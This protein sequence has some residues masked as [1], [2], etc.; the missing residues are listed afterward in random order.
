MKRILCV[1]LLLSLDAVGLAGCYVVSP[2]PPYPPY[3]YPAYI[4]GYQPP[5]TY[6]PP[7][8]GAPRAPGQA[9]ATAAPAPSGTSATQAP[10]VQGAPQGSA[11]NCQTVTV[12]GHF[13]TRV[14]QSGARETIWIPTHDQQMCQ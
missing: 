12:E 14:A 7:S 11:R 13:E 9:G 6:V 8:S 1:M 2:Y 3:P 10:G 5:S 4:P